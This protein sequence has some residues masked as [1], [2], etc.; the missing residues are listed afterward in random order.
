MTPADPVAAALGNASLLGVG[1]LL[2]GHRRLAALAALGT[3]VLLKYTASVAATWCELLLLVWWVIGVAHGWFLARGR[4]RLMAPRGQRA[5]VLTLAVVVVLTAG[6]LRTDAYG[7]EAR[8]HEARESGDCEEAVAAQGEVWFGHRVAGSVAVDHGAAVVETCHRL[9]R[10]AAEL[11]AAQTGSIDDLRQGFRILAGVL[12][13]PGHHRT[14][15]TALASFLSELP[16]R[17]S[18]DTADIAAWLLDREPSGDLLDRSARTAARTEPAALV[19]CGDE[20]M[21]RSS[22]KQARTR[23]QRLLDVYPNDSSLDE[24]RSGV[25]EAS[26]AIELDKV[27]GLVRETLDAD[28]GYCAEPA[29]YSGAPAYDKGDSRALFLGS[30]EYTGKLPDSWRTDDPAKAALV[31]CAGSAT[32]GASVESCYYETTSRYSPH[33]VTFHKAKIPVKVY[34]LR[35]GKRVAQRQLQIGGTSCPPTLH[36]TTYGLDDYGPNANQLVSVGKSDVRDAFRPIM[37]R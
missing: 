21:E 24:A 22:W 27:R 33:H 29:P 31:V 12:D 26:E 1:Y 9:E 6:L 14:V 28:S 19:A 11:A 17:D 37:K 34:E 36:Y 35:T 23:Y 5:G 10:A 8:V 30:D 32:N 18:C 15:E 20:L 2:L 16:T 7:I 25:R 3:I 13:E 4:V